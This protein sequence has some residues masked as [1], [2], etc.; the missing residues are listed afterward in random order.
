MDNNYKNKKSDEPVAKSC[1]YHV[2]DGCDCV[3]GTYC[4]DGPDVSNCRFE[5]SC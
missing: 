2:V 3:V 1:C 4:C 5:S